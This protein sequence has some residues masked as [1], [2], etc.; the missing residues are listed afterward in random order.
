VIRFGLRLTLAGGRE[1]LTRLVLIATAVTIGVGLLLAVLAGANAVNTQIGRYAWL[2]TEPVAAK[3]DGGSLW[4]N[5]SFDFFEGTRIDRV[6]VA[7]IKPDAPVPPGIPR[8]PGPGEYYASP[9]LRAKM[10]ATPADQLASRYPGH[11][12]G[13]IGRDALQS[14]ESLLL[15]VGRTPDQLSSLPGAERVDE[16]GHTVPQIAADALD[17]ILAVIAAGLLFPVLIFIGTA[18]RLSAARREQRFAAMRLVGATPRQ[19]SVIS[20]VEAGVAAVAGTLLGFGLFALLRGPVSKIPFS[21]TTFFY[22]D[23]SL[24]VLDVAVV[25]VGVPVCAVLAARIALRRVRISPLGVT[26]QVTPRPPSPWRLTPLVLGLLELTYFI[27]RRPPTGPGQTAAYLPGFLLIM[28]GLVLGGPW[29]TMVGAR[30]L[31]RRSSRPAT[32]IAARRLADNPRAGFRAVSGL[33]IALFV[34]SVAT[35]IISTIVDNRGTHPYAARAATTLSK[36]FD[37]ETRPTAAPAGLVDDLRSIP[38][39][40]SVI[41]VRLN[42]DAGPV[43][44]GRQTPP[45]SLVACADLTSRRGE[46]HCAPGAVVAA[47]WAG[48]LAGFSSHG[49]NGVPGADTVWQTSPVPLSELAHLPIGTIQV[50]TN[51]TA[52][53]LERARTRLATAYPDSRF[54][55]SRATDGDSD[56][57][58]ALIG[59]RRLA[60]VVILISLAIAGCG[61]AVSIAGGLSERKRPFSLLRLSGAPLKTLRRVVTLESAV[62]LLTVAIVA[63]GAGLL[64]AHLFLV[65]QLQYHL[66]PPGTEYYVIV[67]VGLAASL[68]II[69]STLP[70]LG[71]ITGPET[72]RND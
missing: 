20:A 30:V 43:T 47:V 45:D 32:L 10:A 61:L 49:N 37:Q 66:R 3:N 24:T 2:N 29:L 65:A 41:V 34:T 48:D 51:G 4:W 22:S 28:T 64:A 19:I 17:L 16:I 40:R 72:A 60:D 54:P 5:Q 50:G 62:P 63:I 33:V 56:I 67:V 39:V 23:L 59:W 27:G 52:A 31:A 70:F 14:P 55:P 42:P 25:S 53:A 18:T 8:L 15:I 26:R 69:A 46:G 58:K 35:G 11:E 71:R 9:A 57:T 6:D 38:G 68:G 36:Y 44:P 1:A 21:G 7:A 13:T 12:V